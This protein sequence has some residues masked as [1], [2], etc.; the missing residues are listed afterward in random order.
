MVVKIVSHF[1][2]LKEKSPKHTAQFIDGLS[3]DTI[4]NDIIIIL[5]PLASYD[6]ESAYILKATGNKLSESL[7]GSA[8]TG[9]LQDPKPS[10]RQLA[11]AILVESKSV[12]E[13]VKNRLREIVSPNALT[14]TP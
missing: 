13:I 1:S 2:P 11:C 12:D 8:L 9:F 14:Q 4:R 3:D 7:I 6:S 10:D 5:M